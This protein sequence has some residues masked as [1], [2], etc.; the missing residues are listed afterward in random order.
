MLRAYTEPF[1]S[2]EPAAVPRALAPEATEV[3]RVEQPFATGERSPGILFYRSQAGFW[4]P[5]FLLQGM[6]FEPD[7]L[8]LHFAAEDVV[9]DGRGLHG[10]YVELARQVVWRVVEQGE[11][12]ATLSRAPTY[13]MRISEIPKSRE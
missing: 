10:L 7:K 8:T 5:Y 3:P 13:V 4:R 9:I 1:R 11:R 2:E 12:Y 6:R